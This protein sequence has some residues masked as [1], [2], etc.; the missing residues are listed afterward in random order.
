MAPPTASPSAQAP[1]PFVPALIV[2]DLQNSF[3]EEGSLAVPGG[4]ALVPVINSLLS[5]PFALKLA[6]QDWHP[7]DHQSFASAHPG[8]QPFS[9]TA[10][11]T[12][13]RDPSS[14]SATALWPDHC[15][16]DT[17][18]AAFAPGLHADTFDAVV[19]KGS[20]RDVETYSFMSDIF[21]N[22]GGDAGFSAD[23]AELLRDKGVSHCFVVGLAGDFCVRYSALDLAK[24]GFVTYVVEDAIEYID[25]K[26][27]KQES[28]RR[29]KEGNVTTVTLGGNELGWLKG[30]SV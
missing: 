14:T 16:Q 23:A 22:S 21:G 30:G 2:I 24:A 13:I 29:W 11:M 17:P 15:V 12:N 9:S 7:A 28:G 8:A 27:G 10:T 1:T 5:L 6:S 25:P 18:G 20:R 4:S 19:R 26:D 3:L